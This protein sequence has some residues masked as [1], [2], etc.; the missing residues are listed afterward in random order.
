MRFNDPQLQTALVQ[1]RQTS[2]VLK[3]SKAD[4]IW[5]E[6]RVSAARQKAFEDEAIG[7]SDAASLRNAH[8][9]YWKT[10]VQVDEDVSPYIRGDIGSV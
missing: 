9:D 5:F 3:R 7:A 2:D 6:Q 4:N 10:F 1:W 8:T